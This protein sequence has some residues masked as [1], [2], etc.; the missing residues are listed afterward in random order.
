MPIRNFTETWSMRAIAIT[1]EFPVMERALDFFSDHFSLSKIGSKVRA[2]SIEGMYTT[3]CP[4]NDDFPSQEREGAC[5]AD[6]YF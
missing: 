5:G 4:I 2:T 6:F 1:P 3:L